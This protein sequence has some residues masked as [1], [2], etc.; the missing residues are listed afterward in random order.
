MSRPWTPYHPGPLERLA[1]GLWTLED[2]VPGLP[3]ARRRMTVIRRRDGTL[4]FFNAV[5]FGP[6][7]EAAVRGLGTP[8]ALVVPNRFHAL[9][10]GPFAE[11]LGLTAY[12]PREALAD[13]APRVGARPIDEL[14]GDEALQV[15]TVEGFRTQEVAL[16]VGTT[17]KTLVVADLVTNAPH[18]PG[19]VGLAM[20]L[21]GFTGPEPKL[22]LPVRKRVGRDL[23]AVK[24][25]L[26][27]LAGTPG[28][29]R[30]MPSHGAVVSADVA[31]VLRRIAAT[32]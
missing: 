10:A 3:G 15:L 28:L 17:E 1:D 18:G 24:A 32:L 25:Q 6:E 22:P 29:V 26:E 23:R 9:D 19:L 5:P 16:L 4:T 30:L 14:R 31:A 27:Q 20:R 8:T 2:D 11:R 21:V 12:A 13:L 7:T